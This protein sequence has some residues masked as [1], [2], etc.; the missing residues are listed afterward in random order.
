MS[1]SGYVIEV[2][3]ACF[4]FIEIP[5]AASNIAVAYETPACATVATLRTSSVNEH[6]QCFLFPPL[7]IIMAGTNDAVTIGVQTVELEKHHR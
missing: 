2:W 3:F 1:S 5:G 6:G 4:V 7:T